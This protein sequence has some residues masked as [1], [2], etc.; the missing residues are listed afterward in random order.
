MKY[1]FNR[2][3][4]RW[5][6]WINERPFRRLGSTE[7]FRFPASIADPITLEHVSIEYFGPRGA[8]YD[9][10][11]LGADFHNKSHAGLAVSLVNESH[12]QSHISALTT[13]DFGFY[14]GLSSAFVDPIKNR[15][16]SLL[17]A[18]HCLPSGH[19]DICYAA[20]CH[21]GSNV[22]VF[23][24]LAHCLVLIFRKRQIE[25]ESCV[26]R[27]LDEALLDQGETIR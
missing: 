10:G 16:A 24:M 25:D 17:Q 20:G 26:I 4:D 5:L 9:Y 21:V 7:I 1:R 2:G 22:H 13:I 12:L 3:M 23:K 6:V 19:L 27:I 14:K 8:K 11:L 18:T 15:I